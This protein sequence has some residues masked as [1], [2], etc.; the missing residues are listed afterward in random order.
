MDKVI[1]I[2]GAS[3]GIGAAAARLLV[4]K[5]YQVVV[6]GRSPEKTT[7]IAKE[8]NAPYHVADYAELAQVVRFA[9]ELLASYP[10][11]DVLANNA[12]GLFRKSTTVDGFGKHFQVNHLAG[13]LLTNLLLERLIE[14]G[15]RIIQTS[16]IVSST[17]ARIDIGSFA[18]DGKKDSLR[19]YADSKLANILFTKELHRRFHIKGINSVAFHPGS[20]V[21]N[22]AYEFD[23]VFRIYRSPLLRWF[24]EPPEDAGAILAWF[25]E[26][27]PGRDWISGEYYEKKR[28]PPAWRI[29]RQVRDAQLAEA[30]W[31][32]SAELLALYRPR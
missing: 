26:G 20:I 15:A 12:G 18:N 16:S 23:W 19:A 22:F 29:N 8:L 17:L 27:V 3:D 32:H 25:I 31:D 14:S 9:N 13:F 1:V 30:L 21:S 2:T 4:R 5:G 6:H 24:F 10:R 7:A 28:V 11:I